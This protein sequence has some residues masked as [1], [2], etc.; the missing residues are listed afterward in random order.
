MIEKIDMTYRYSRKQGD[1]G[2]EP[3]KCTESP[4][5]EN[6]KTGRKER[7]YAMQIRK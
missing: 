6:L 2:L 4:S 1:E 5:L 3:D 7:S